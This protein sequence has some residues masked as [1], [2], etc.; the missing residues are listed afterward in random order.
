MFLA[1]ITESYCVRQWLFAR[2]IWERD[3][4]TDLC[5]GKIIVINEPRHIRLSISIWSRAFQ[6]LVSTSDLTIL[7]VTFGKIITAGWKYPIGYHVMP[8]CRVR[9]VLLYNLVVSWNT[10]CSA[11][12]ACYSN[13]G[14]L[15]N[16]SGTSYGL[17]G[18]PVLYEGGMET[19]LSEVKNI[20]EGL[21]FWI[22]H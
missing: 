17:I 6:H 21:L 11:L 16:N 13:N 20:L 22:F 14:I 2:F 15:G 10:G 19:R 12:R 3:S 4:V 8:H 9:T 7:K 18:C 1:G 5:S